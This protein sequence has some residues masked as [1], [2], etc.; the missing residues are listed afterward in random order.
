MYTPPEQSSDSTIPPAGASLPIR[1]HIRGDSW[2]RGE[3]QLMGLAAVVFLMMIAFFGISILNC[4]GRL[5]RRRP[6][7]ILPPRKA[8]FFIAPPSYAEA[9]TFRY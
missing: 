5:R 6:Q 2:S 8:V 3:L 1:H 4:F 9:T 7:T